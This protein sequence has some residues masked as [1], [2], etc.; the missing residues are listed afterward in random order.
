M[1]NH[2]F[3]DGLTSWIWLLFCISVAYGLFWSSSTANLLSSNTSIV[4][5][6]HLKI[7]S[8]ESQMWPLKYVLWHSYSRLGSLLLPTGQDLEVQGKTSGC[9][10][11]KGDSPIPAVAAAIIPSV[12]VGAGPG[13]AL[14]P[15]RHRL[16]PSPN[17]WWVITWS[18]FIIQ[19]M[20]VLLQSKHFC[21]LCPD[22]KTVSQPP[23]ILGFNCF[24]LLSSDGT[25]PPCP[26]PSSSLPPSWYG[27][28]PVPTLLMWWATVAVSRG[29]LW[30]RRRKKKNPPP[31]PCLLFRAHPPFQ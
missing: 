3:C 7:W 16:F 19:T 30:R 1:L 13:W 23:L 20:V 29:L 15:W 28:F 10:L 31:P 4:Y 22:A 14:P 9:A 26:Q 5:K 18:W 6:T 2:S 12:A 8:P 25:P 21:W 11:H 24:S 27:F 17:R